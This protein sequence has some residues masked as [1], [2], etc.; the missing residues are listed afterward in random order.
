[1]D[2]NGIS[3]NKGEIVMYQPD[4]TIRLEVRLENDTVWLNRQQ[5]AQLF[6]RDVKTIGKHINN[7]L[8]EELRTVPTVAKLAIVQ[9]SRQSLV[10]GS[11]QTPLCLRADGYRQDNYSK[12]IITRQ[13]NERIW[14]HIS[15]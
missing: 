11:W 3:V 13:R 7:A 4:E 8:Q 2:T 9:K 5:I 6:G 1:M 14:E 12:P 15:I 10:Q